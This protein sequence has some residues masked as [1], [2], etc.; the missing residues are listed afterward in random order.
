MRDPAP[1]PGRRTAQRRKRDARYRRRARESVMVVPIEVGAGVLDFLIRTRWLD[2]LDA[3]DKHA[4]AA[5]IGA[6]LKASA[7]GRRR[8]QRN[9]PCD[10]SARFAL[11]PLHMITQ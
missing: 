7:E 5:A 3:G 8:R 6:M 10:C 9:A 11:A 2:E 4:I 1:S